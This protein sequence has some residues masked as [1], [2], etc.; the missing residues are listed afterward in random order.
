MGIFAAYNLSP[1]FIWVKRLRK[2]SEDEINGTE[3]EN[4][5]SDRVNWVYRISIRHS[6]QPHLLCSITSPQRDLSSNLRNNL[7]SLGA[8]WRFP[9][10]NMLPNL[11]TSTLK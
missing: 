1:F 8:Y 5:W 7:V 6:I 10:D 9:C 11:R 2:N 3:I 4:A